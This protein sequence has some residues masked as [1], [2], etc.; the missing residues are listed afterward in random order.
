MTTKPPTLFDITDKAHLRPMT[1]D[2]SEAYVALKLSQAKRPSKV[3]KGRDLERELREHFKI[4]TGAELPWVLAIGV[5]RIETCDPDG[6]FDLD[7]AMFALGM[8]SDRPGF[9]VLW[10]Y[11]LSRGREKVNGQA[12]DLDNWAVTLHPWGVPST[13]G[14]G[15]IWDAQKGYKLGLTGDKYVDNYL[16]TLEAWQ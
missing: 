1:R 9:A 6:D 7:M 5:K 2:E 16:D 10:A 11:S 4:E 14:A 8:M 3:V 12:I 15:H 13:E